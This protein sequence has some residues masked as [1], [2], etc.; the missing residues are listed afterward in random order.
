M[1]LIMCFAG[2]VNAQAV[3]WADT[4]KEFARK[5]GDNLYEPV[6][7]GVVSYKYENDKFWE[8][9]EGKPDDS[10]KP[11]GYLSKRGSKI[12]YF[13]R[14]D[15]M[16]GYYVPNEYR[17]YR[18]EPSGKEDECALLYEGNLYVGLGEIRYKVDASFPSEILGFFLF[19]H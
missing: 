9:L 12:Y 15:Q 4:D 1:L 17:Y 16:V 11:K 2:V 3:R 10:G 19:V 13:D 5:I 6:P 18:V 14:N 7:A 8:L